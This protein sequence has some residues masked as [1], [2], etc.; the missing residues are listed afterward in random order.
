V[1]RQVREYWTDVAGFSCA[2]AAEA[3]GEEAAK[4]EEIAKRERRGRRRRG[5]GG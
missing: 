4:R 2:K 3:K 5:R 1:H